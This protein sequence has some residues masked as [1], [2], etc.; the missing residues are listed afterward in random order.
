MSVESG[1]LGRRSTQLLIALRLLAVIT[2]TGL[3]WAGG[4]LSVPCMMCTCCTAPL[5]RTLRRNGAPTSSVLAYWLGNP[6][7]NPAECDSHP[8][9]A[10]PGLGCQQRSRIFRL[11]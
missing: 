11:S 10:M 1:P 2:I 9:R 3:T 7:L 5:A 6:T 4:L 8:V